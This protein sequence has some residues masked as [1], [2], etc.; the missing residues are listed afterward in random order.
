[1]SDSSG[2]NGGGLV[3]TE[4]FLMDAHPEWSTLMLLY[5]AT[6]PLLAVP[7]SLDCHTLNGPF[8]TRGEQAEIQNFPLQDKGTEPWAL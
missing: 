3:W 1:M 4:A 6:P 5:P 2:I 7:L 8:R